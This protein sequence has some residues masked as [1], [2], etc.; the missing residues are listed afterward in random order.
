MGGE[1][2][3]RGR[4]GVRYITGGG[5]RLPVKYAH[6]IYITTNDI[7]DINEGCVRALSQYQVV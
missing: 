4:K 2:E 6:K 3:K 1:R 5:G 7:N